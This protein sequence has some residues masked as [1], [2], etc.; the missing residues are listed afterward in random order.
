MAVEEVVE[1][2]AAVDQE[3]HQDCHPSHRMPWYQCQH[4]MD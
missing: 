2:E 1:E 3:A 4:V